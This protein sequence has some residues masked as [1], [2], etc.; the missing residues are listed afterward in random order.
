MKNSTKPP[1]IR[2]NSK[3][4]HITTITNSEYGYPTDYSLES[5]FVHLLNRREKAPPF[6]VGMNRAN[7]SF[8]VEDIIISEFRS[9]K[10]I[11][12]TVD[13]YHRSTK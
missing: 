2:P 11:V 8:Y 3:A 13:Y 7:G 10:K 12:E 5:R 9:Q 1:R 6:R 4:F